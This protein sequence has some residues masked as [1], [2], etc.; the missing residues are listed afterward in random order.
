M[1]KKS[2]S[3]FI[4]F[5][6]ICFSLAYNSFADQKSDLEKKQQQTQKQMQD[7]QKKIE[8]AKKVQNQFTKKKQALDNEITAIAGNVNKLSSQISTLQ[9]DIETK[10]DEIA[11]LSKDEAENTELFKKRMRA[12]YE[13]NSYSYID[14]ILKSESLSDLF[15]RLDV[16]TQV[17][18][19]DQKVISEIVDKKEK[20]SSA[21]VELSNK[22]SDIQAVKS[23]EEK[24]KQQLAEKNETNKEEIEKLADDIEAYRLEYEKNEKES[25][26]IQAQIKEIIRQSTSS[27]TKYTGGV[28][29]WPAPGYGAITSPFGMRFHPKLKVNKLHTGVDIGA[30]SGATVVAANDGVVIISGFSGAYGNYISIDHG[31]GITTLYGHHSANL[32]SKGTKVKR[33]QAIAKVGSTGWSTGAHLHFE[34][35]VNGEYKDPLGYIK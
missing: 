24:E 6:I 23:D 27:N 25:Q 4:I 17:S 28:M 8:S 15:Y 9:S 19:Y 20:I 16:I 22:K 26:R 13:E 2:I 34:V 12:L 1:L 21:K 14:M 7:A 32:V 30:P 33:G 31:G 18:N 5:I 29:A 10:Q 11:Q 3:F 35:M